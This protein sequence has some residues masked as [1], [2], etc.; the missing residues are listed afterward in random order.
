MQAQLNKILEEAKAQLN[1]ASTLAQT[2]DIRVK[3]LGKKGKLTEILRGMGKLSPEERKTTGQ[4]ANKVRAE[5]EKMHEEKFEAV[6]AAAKEA[7]FKIG[8]LD[9]TERDREVTLAV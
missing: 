2:D 9:E 7:H 8:N 4:M 1:E 3:I 6:N 5:V